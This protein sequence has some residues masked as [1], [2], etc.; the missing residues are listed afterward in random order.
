MK[1]HFIGIG[2]IGMSALARHYLHE[3]WQVSGSDLNKSDNTEKLAKE[4]A[5]IVYEQ[6]AANI[7]SSFDLVVYTE[8][9]ANNHPELAAA[10]EG[11]VETINYFEALGRVANQYYLL[12]VAGAHGKTTTTAMLVDILEE[13]S[14]DP[15]AV[16]GSLRT[17]TGSNYRAGKSKYFIAE[18]CEYRRDFLFLEPEVL[19]ITNLEYEHVDYYR[20]LADVQSAFRELALKVPAA[21]AVVA[22]LSDP[23]LKPVLAGLQCRVVD[24][25]PNI[26]LSLK[27]RQPGM[28][29]RLNAA[30]AST[31]ARLVGVEEETVNLALEN[32]AGTW[33][34]FEYKGE[35]NGSPV[36]DDYAHHPTEIRAAIAG[37][38]EL[39]PSKKLVIVFQPHTFSR[40]KELF[41]DF[42]TAL[43]E[44]DRALL[45][46]IYAAREVDNGQVSSRQLVQRIGE[47]GGQAEHFETIPATTQR[48]KELSNPD[49]VIVVMGAGSVTEVA[50]LLTE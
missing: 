23:N 39:Y 40:T 46:P 42:V 18:A 49:T 28:H 30:A 11:G 10:R 7:D 26:S 29:N 6:N 8:A 45:L 22:N 1:I 35:I 5:N 4:G 31:A 47:Q 14:F 32:F 16:V 13:A 36:Y 43:S 17:K 21:G 24:Y 20:D 41:S 37:T 50:R 25:R 3:G 33:R 27:L 2:G 44:A 34:R 15:S 48:L 38:R 9:M 19:V 12:A